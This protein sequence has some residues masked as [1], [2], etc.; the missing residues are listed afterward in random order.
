MITDVSDES[1]ASI[2]TA[3]ILEVEAAGAYEKF[4]SI[5]QITHPF[6]FKA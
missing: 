2:F 5:N 6:T 1:D 4:S 3:P